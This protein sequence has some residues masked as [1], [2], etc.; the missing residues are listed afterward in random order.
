MGIDNTTYASAAPVA[1]AAGVCDDNDNDNDNNIQFLLARVC[2]V[3]DDKNNKP[4]LLV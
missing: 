2:D 1:A 3:E 4:S